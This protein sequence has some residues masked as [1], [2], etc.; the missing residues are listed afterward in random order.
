MRL[1]PYRSYNFKVLAGTAELGAFSDVSGLVAD[2]DTAD[3]RSG[4]D[5][6]QNVRKLPGMRKFGPITLKR[7]YIKDATLWNW[8]QNIANG[9]SDRR[10]LTIILM[11]EARVEVMEWKA[12][13]AFINKIEGPTFKA[14][15]NEVA[16]ESIEVVH[17]GL[18]MTLR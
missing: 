4:T 18:T 10:E 7:G 3:Y 5:I 12:E 6:Q 2:G 16:I 13:G 14:A 1:D 11:D 15:A 9:I 17:E 8:Y